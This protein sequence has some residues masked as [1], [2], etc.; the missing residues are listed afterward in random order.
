MRL[1]LMH[2]FGTY[3]G[4]LLCTVEACAWIEGTLREGY[5][6]G[7]SADHYSFWRLISR[8]QTS[9][10]SLPRTHTQQAELPFVFAHYTT[11]R[12]H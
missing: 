9:Q 2:T 12:L 7:G 3:N 8:N 10:R 1:Y 6:L 4:L 5:I 11:P